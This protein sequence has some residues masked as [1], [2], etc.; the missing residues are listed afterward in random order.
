MGR[1][2]HLLLLSFSYQREVHMEDGSHLY[3]GIKK[4]LYNPHL[5][6][7]EHFEGSEDGNND[8]DVDTKLNI[9]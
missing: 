5:Y 3:Y 2:Y 4:M 7:Y 6:I 1:V 8:D 9:D